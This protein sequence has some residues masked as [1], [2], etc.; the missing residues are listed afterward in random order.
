MSACGQSAGRLFHSVSSAA[1]KIIAVSPSDSMHPWCG[2]TQQTTTFVGD[3]PTDSRRQMGWTVTGRPGWPSWRPP[4]ADQED[5]AAPLALEWC[6]RAVKLLTTN[7]Y[8]RIEQTTAGLL[9]P[10]RC[11]KTESCNSPGPRRHEMNVWTS[12]FTASVDIALTSG[13]SCRSW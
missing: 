11:C 2:R 10:R 7:V 3:V 1:A 4:D 6:G 12:V 9:D 13:R 5:S 8:S